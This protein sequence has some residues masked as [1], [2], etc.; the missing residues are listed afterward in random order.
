ML[1]A[2]IPARGGSR[3]IASK[4]LQEVGGRSLLA[5]TITTASD[6]A[7][8]VVV[9]TDDSAIAAEAV[10]YGAKVVD[11]PPDLAGDEVTSEDVLLDVLAEVGAGEWFLFLQCTSPFLTHED[12]E[13]VAAPV[14]HGTAD[15]A[16]A[17]AEFHGHVWGKRGRR[18]IDG[19]NFDPRA[20]ATPPRQERPPQW[21]ETGAAYALRT[22]L[23]ER[24]GRRFFGRIVA[25]ECETWRGLDI[26]TPADLAVA[27]ALAP[28]MDGAA[29]E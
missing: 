11:R 8:V 14:R 18:V 10:A 9:S 28:M 6:V 27:R 13:R 4:N 16:F 26:D 20:G 12:L 3:G 22:V 1:V 23:F 5:R 29:G 17:A 21:I 2:V 25:V 15:V 19:V 24:L 7:D